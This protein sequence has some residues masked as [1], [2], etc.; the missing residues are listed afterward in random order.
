MEGGRDLP[1]WT[2]SSL[3]V[4]SMGCAG[5]MLG[6]CT[7]TGVKDSF[8]ASV[9][10]VQGFQFNEMG[11]PLPCLSPLTFS[12]ANIPSKYRHDSFSR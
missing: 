12:Y 11:V 2:S 7:P 8:G 6:S 1:T 5:A 3:V 4:S 10:E 9:V